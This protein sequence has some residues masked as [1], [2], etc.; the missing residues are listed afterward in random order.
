MH[1]DEVVH[2][3]ARADRNSKAPPHKH[4]TTTHGETVAHKCENA[5]SRRP[6]SQ[7][8]VACQKSLISSLEDVK[9]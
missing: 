8:L 9:A 6:H 5:T 2:E 7:T 1:V 4:K 3:R